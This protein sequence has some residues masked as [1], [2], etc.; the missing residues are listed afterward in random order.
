MIELR[1]G[2]YELRLRFRDGRE[3]LRLTDHLELFATEP[4][5]VVLRGQ[6]WRVLALTE[7]VRPGFAGRVICEAAAAGDA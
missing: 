6:R 4:G 7:P 5:E 1:P 3:E 2:A